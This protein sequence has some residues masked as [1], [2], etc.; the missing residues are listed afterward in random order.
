LGL[1]AVR[2]VPSV[3]NPHCEVGKAAAEDEFI[4]R[5]LLREA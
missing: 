2:I 5:R 4:Q 1:R 3:T